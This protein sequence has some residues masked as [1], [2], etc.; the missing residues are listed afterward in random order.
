MRLLIEV[1]I[2]TSKNIGVL[3]TVILFT[4]IFKLFLTP[5]YIVRKRNQYLKK[6]IYSELNEIKK[7][8]RAN[9][10]KLVRQELKRQKEVLIEAN[11]IKDKK[12]MFLIFLVELLALMI[13]TG[14]FKNYSTETN[15]LW[16]DISQKDTTYGL[17]MINTMFCAL[18]MYYANKNDEFNTPKLIVLGIILYMVFKL[19]V[20]SKSIVVVYF[21]IS[22]VFSMCINIIFSSDYF[23]VNNKGK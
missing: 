19:S 21:I 5:I 16:F 9:K 1:F 7:E 18:G 23:K 4:L 2:N 8:L 6:N 3:L 17:P 11:C 14:V 12:F 13:L 15:V 22:N 20:N 10:D